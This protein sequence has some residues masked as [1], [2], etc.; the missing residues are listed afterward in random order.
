[1]LSPSD[2]D[3][4][5][6][7]ELCSFLCVFLSALRRFLSNTPEQRGHVPSVNSSSDENEDEDEEDDDNNIRI[8]AQCWEYI[9]CEGYKQHRSDTARQTFTVPFCTF[10]CGAPQMENKRKE[11]RVMWQHWRRRGWASGNPW[12]TREEGTTNGDVCGVQVVN[13]GGKWKKLERFFVDTAA[14]S[15]GS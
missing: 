11:D 6:S 5:Q 8:E 3:E 12:C 13:K 7:E 4:A 2:G 14:H 1:M 15:S 10:P 9:H